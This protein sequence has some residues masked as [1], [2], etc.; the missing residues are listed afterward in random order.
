MSYLLCRSKG[1]RELVSGVCCSV[2]HYVLQCVLQCALQCA[3]KC[4]YFC[5]IVANAR[6]N[7]L[8]ECVAVP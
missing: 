8:Q 4:V 3:L 1:A 6:V 2:M 7:L 5:C